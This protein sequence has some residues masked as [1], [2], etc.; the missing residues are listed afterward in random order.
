MTGVRLRDSARWITLVVW[1]LSLSFFIS[2]LNQQLR[3][4]SWLARSPCDEG[5]CADLYSLPPALTIINWIYV[6]GYFFTTRLR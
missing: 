6:L 2:S 1:L 3:A 4:S 5:Y